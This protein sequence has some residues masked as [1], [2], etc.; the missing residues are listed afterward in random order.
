MGVC[1]SKP[2]K[3]LKV[4][5][6]NFS[7]ENLSKIRDS[8][9]STIV[10]LHKL[11]RSCE[12]GIEKILLNKTSKEPAVI[13]KKKQICCIEK[14]KDFQGSLYEL[15]IIINGPYIL[16]LETETLISKIEKLFSD[17]ESVIFTDD[18]SKI[19]SGND[20]S[21]EKM[22]NKALANYPLNQNEALMLV[23][24]ELQKLTKKNSD[25]DFKRRKYTRHSTI[26]TNIN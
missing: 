13:I 5:S 16:K 9:I 25:G 1:L 8:L 19:T 23:D 20:S 3:N 12:K 10:R 7:P 2:K 22:V 17:L 4:H 24:Q 14:L 26:K 6:I 15:D 18:V 11:T 21:Y